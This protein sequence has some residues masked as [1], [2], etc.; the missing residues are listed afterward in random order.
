MMTTK[1][2]SKLFAAVVVC[3]A[4]CGALFAQELNCDEIAAMARMVRAKSSAALTAEKKK[5]GNSY[6]AR[7]IFA[8][9]SLEFHRME[10]RAAVQ[11]LNLIP[12]DDGQ[13]NTWMTL[14]DSLCSSETVS[15]M[16]SLGRLG[17]GLPRGLTKAVL[18]VP[19][20]LQEYVAY[21]LI[22]TR[23]PHSDYA[24]QMQTVCRDKHPEF[25]KAVEEL[26]SDK[27]DWFIKHVFNPQGCHA[28]TL[29]E[30]E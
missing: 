4:F 13:Q 6:R 5:A 27:R 26:P 21:A 17:E 12:K 23:D 8:A 19:N 29:P 22:S 20:K 14:G 30:A 28:L 9:R 15:D 3:M 11:L 7:V 25:M 24:V 2:L 18:L 16:R 1:R 10:R